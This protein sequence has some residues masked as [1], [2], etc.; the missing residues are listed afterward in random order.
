MVVSNT[1]TGLPHGAVAFEPPTEAQLPDAI[2]PVD[3][4]CVLQ[5]SQYVPGQHECL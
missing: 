3:A 4:A 1:T 2:A 5:I